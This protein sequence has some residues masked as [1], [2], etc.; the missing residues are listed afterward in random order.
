M[1]HGMKTLDE[2][3]GNADVAALLESGWVTMDAIP[4]IP[5]ITQKPGAVTYGPLAETPIDP[6]VVLVRLTA[7]SLMVLSDA[8]PGLR[9]EG[10]P[11]CHIIAVAKEQGEVAASVGCQLSRVRTGMS[12]SE[13]TVAIPASKVAS[14]IA[15]LR[16]TAAADN[17]VAGY[18]SKDARRFAT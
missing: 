7:K 11:Q 13:M 15:A 9:I 8:L 18:A 4:Q 12:N 2:V 5:V 6:D 10:K 17:A 16:A 1:T 3:A 14:T